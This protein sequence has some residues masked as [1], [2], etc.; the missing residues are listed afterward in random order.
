[1]N[2]GRKLFFKVYVGVYFNV[3]DMFQPMSFARYVLERPCLRH[4]R[5]PWKNMNENLKIIETA[6]TVL[7]ESWK[8]SCQKISKSKDWNCLKILKTIKTNTKSSEYFLL[9]VESLEEICLQFSKFL[10]VNL[11]IK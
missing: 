1:M 10:K 5:H 11:I 9:L 8:Y 6:V 3:W 7:K 4:P 2:F